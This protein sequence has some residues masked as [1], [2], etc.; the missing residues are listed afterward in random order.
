LRTRKSRRKRTIL[1]A[2]GSIFDTE[3]RPRRREDT[4]GRCFGFLFFANEVAEFLG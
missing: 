4:E 2:R 3:G 1:A